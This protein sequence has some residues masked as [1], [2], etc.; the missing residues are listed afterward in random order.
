MYQKRARD[1][2]SPRTPAPSGDVEAAMWELFLAVGTFWKL[3]DA[4]VGHRL[5]LKG[6]MANRIGL[7]AKYEGYYRLA[8]DLIARLA[9]DLGGAD[10]AY[11]HV[12]TQMA[13]DPDSEL[14]AVQK[15]VSKEFIAWR[16]ALGGFRNFGGLNYRGY[17]GGANIAGEPTPYRTRDGAA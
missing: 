3:D 7:N 15:Y 10:K 5:R 14:A 12:F 9:T 2:L 8:T 11:A 13:T 16:L 17:I 6:F 1:A 4:T